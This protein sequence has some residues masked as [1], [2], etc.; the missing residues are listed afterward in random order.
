MALWHRKENRL[1]QHHIQAHY[2]SKSSK[3][4]VM[5]SGSKTYEA[6]NSCIRF[7]LGVLVELLGLHLESLQTL[8][9]LHE[10]H[11]FIEAFLAIYILLDGFCN[12]CEF[13]DLCLLFT[14]IF[15]SS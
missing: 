5:L 7:G 15:M 14:F 11:K 10:V 12:K 13:L 6:F 4:K 3:T 9:V 8:A 1:C 2:F